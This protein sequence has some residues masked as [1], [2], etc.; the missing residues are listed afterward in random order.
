M[1]KPTLLTSLL[2]STDIGLVGL[3]STMFVTKVDSLHSVARLH[4]YTTRV[5]LREG[6]CTTHCCNT[7][8]LHAR[9]SVNMRSNSSVRDAF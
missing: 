9:M 1:N 8:A 4:L 5:L 3:E 7:N 2:P 6:H